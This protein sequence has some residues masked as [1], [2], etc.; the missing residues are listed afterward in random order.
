MPNFTVKDI[1]HTSQDIETGFPKLVIGNSKFISFPDKGFKSKYEFNEWMYFEGP[2]VLSKDGSVYRVAASGL[3]GFSTKPFS[4]YYSPRQRFSGTS[5][6]PTVGKEY[7][8][9]QIWSN[10]NKSGGTFSFSGVRTGTYLCLEAGRVY[11]NYTPP[12]EPT[13]IGGRYTG[14]SPGYW[15]TSITPSKFKRVD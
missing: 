12:S 9:A 4:A 2:I 7:S 11:S 5:F 8:G 13:W 10:Y 14:G 3:G 6:S 15:S 1:K